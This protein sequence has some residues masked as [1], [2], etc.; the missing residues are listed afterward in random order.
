MRTADARAQLAGYAWPGNVREL[1]NYVERCLVLRSLL[2]PDALP[3]A[4]PPAIDATEPL[5]RARDHAI[6][7]F[8]HAYWRN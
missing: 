8:E 1:R 7:M 4:A 6:R 5:K 2:P 3:T